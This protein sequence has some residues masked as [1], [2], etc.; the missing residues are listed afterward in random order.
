VQIEPQAPPSGTRA[1]YD[2]TADGVVHV[3]SIGPGDVPFTADERAIYLGAS[4][5]GAGVAFAVGPFGSSTLYL[6]YGNE[7][8]FEIGEGVVFAGIAEG[9]GRI[10]Y[11]EGG[12]LWRF[13]AA[14]GERAAFSS[15]TVTPVNISEDGTAAYFVSTGKLTSEPNPNGAF[16]KAGKQNLYLSKEGTVS[17]V[18]TVTERD[19]T[20]FVNGKSE[21]VDGLGL[22]AEA[23]S[24]PISGKF[25]IDPSR[26]TP[27]GTALLF[28]SRAPL[29]GYDSEGHAE[30]Y[31]YD[32]AEGRLHCLSCNPTG[33]A[34]TGDATLQS[35]GREGFAL[36]YPQAWIQNLRPDGRRAIFQSTEA[37]VPGDT[38]GRQDVYEWEE[39]GVG[40]C[41]TA[42]GCLFLLSS[43]HSLRNDYVW[44][45]SESGNDVFILSS[46]LLLPTDQDETPSI[47]DARAGGGFPEPAK[48]E[49]E[50]E[51][52][53]P[54]LA[55]A[56]ALPDAQTP[57]HGAGDNFKPHRCG[58]GK[59]KVKR[60]GKVRCLKKH[61]KHSRHRAGSNRGG[62]G[63]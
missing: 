37:L 63:K 31:R 49:C 40:S 18:G 47:Y 42:G 58:K 60:G 55:P 15:G 38:D 25:A 51:G 7:E 57:V 13:D 45:V 21:H 22:W 10:F 14:T 56:P 32:S 44:A 26:A 2:R 34:A 27:D 54:Q 28:Q 52:C 9:G 12:R 3:V 16:A 6:R 36:Y 11:L 29:A 41:A 17:F 30:V 20:G 19:V 33:A 39:Q 5:D 50:G 62:D 43:G 24:A 8:T 1:I 35:E 4:L 61:K 46:D 53:R 48:A 23:A 59:R